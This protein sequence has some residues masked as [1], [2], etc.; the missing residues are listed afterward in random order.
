MTGRATLLL[1]FAGLLV[2]ANV[3]VAWGKGPESVTITGPG[4]QSPVELVHPT[5]W[6]ISCNPRCPPDPMVRLLE[7]SGLWY[8]TGGV[9]QPIEA[10]VAD[11]GSAHV[12]TWA[13]PGLPGGEIHQLIFLD[14][15]HGPIIHTP[16]QEGLQA[17]G[18]GVVGWFD[19]SEE[20]V[21]TLS[22][23]GAP[24]AKTEVDLPKG[25]TPVQHLGLGALAGLALATLIRVSGRESSVPR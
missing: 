25:L 23:L 16:D 10:P 13:M 17:W 15:P 19:V 6:P 1:C 7:M 11:P 9:P 8:A 24:L 2:L 20:I 14:A 12:L 4:S 5:D 18:S 3:G 22:S 21:E